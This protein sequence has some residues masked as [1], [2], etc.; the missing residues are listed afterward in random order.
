MCSVCHTFIPVYIIKC[1]LSVFILLYL[2]NAHC[3]NGKAT[4]LVSV[5]IRLT[6]PLN[7]TGCQENTG[8]KN[9]DLAFPHD[10]HTNV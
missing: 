8:F 3:V 6:T 9:V 7:V 10:I 5:L 2:A 1:Q 4:G